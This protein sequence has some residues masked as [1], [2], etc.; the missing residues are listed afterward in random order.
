MGANVK[1]ALDKVNERLGKIDW[2]NISGDWRPSSVAGN[3]ISTA[4][5]AVDALKSALK[6]L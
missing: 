2:D 6:A 1:A 4:I 3:N 5:H